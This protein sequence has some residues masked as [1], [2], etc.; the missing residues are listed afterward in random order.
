[1][2]GKFDAK[3]YARSLSRLM[4]MAD[5]CVTKPGGAIHTQRLLDY[6]AAEFERMTKAQCLAVLAA[7]DHNF[8]N[9]LL[10]DGNDAVIGYAYSRKVFVSLRHDKLIGPVHIAKNANGVKRRRQSQ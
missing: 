5:V 3:V 9:K 7:I 2:T 4:E 8:E 1:M 6:A 10:K